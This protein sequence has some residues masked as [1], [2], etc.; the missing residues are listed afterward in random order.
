M[1][2][3]IKYKTGVKESDLSAL[4]NKLCSYRHVESVSIVEDQS[5]L[6][7]LK[8]E[9]E[10]LKLDID[11]CKNALRSEHDTML[12]NDKLK[13]EN[14]MLKRPAVECGKCGALFIPGGK[15]SE[16]TCGT[17]LKEDQAKL[18]EALRRCGIEANNALYFADSSDYRSALFGIM[19]EA[20]PDKK[21]KGVDELE[22]IEDKEVC[23]EENGL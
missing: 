18:I 9:N 7:R 10:Q 5:E 14:E 4:I 1:E 21:D 6:D 8:Q 13:Q 20:M 3:V 17:C 23:G 11:V 16:S 12:M 2:L 22:Y 19:W 15:G